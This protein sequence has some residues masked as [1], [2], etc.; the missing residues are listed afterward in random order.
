MQFENSSFQTSAGS[1]QGCRN[2]SRF[3][4]LASLFITS[5]K[6]GQAALYCAKIFGRNGH[7]PNK[8]MYQRMALFGKLARSPIG[9]FFRKLQKIHSG[10]SNLSSK[11]QFRS[12]QPGGPD[13]MAGFSIGSC[14]VVRFQLGQPGMGIPQC[15]S[16]IHQKLLFHGTFRQIPA[17]IPSQMSS[18]GE[19]AI[20]SRRH[21]GRRF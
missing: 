6:P 8:T 14:H 1:L 11:H 12:I 18:G 9:K 7:V 5:G 13:R 10:R 21:L 19:H 3:H 20:Y 17:R 15:I 16:R 2:R 4:F